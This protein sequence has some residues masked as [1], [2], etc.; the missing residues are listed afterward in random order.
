[1]LIATAFTTPV[2]I[3]ILESTSL[4]MFVAVQVTISAVYLQGDT[5]LVVGLI[6][7][8]RLTKAEKCLI[9]R[10]Y[11]SLVEAQIGLIGFA[12]R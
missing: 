11:C 6:G 10:N 5:T 9:V 12:R 8:D 2:K 3:R 7:N 4:L 1:M